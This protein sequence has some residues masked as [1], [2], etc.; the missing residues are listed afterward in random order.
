LDSTVSRIMSVHCA[1]LSHLS[2]FRIIEVAMCVC[3]KNYE[4]GDHLIWHCERFETERH[5]H[6]TA[7][8]VQIGTPVLDLCALKKWRGMKCCLDFLG[9]LGIRIL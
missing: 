7:L 8:D 5:R 4:T 6:R 9:S 2:R 3:L 1:A